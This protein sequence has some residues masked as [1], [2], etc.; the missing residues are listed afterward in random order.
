M[1]FFVEMNYLTECES[2]GD[3]EYE[4]VSTLSH[5]AQPLRTNPYFQRLF[6]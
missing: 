1:N 5:S 3:D 6:Q 4:S 2:V